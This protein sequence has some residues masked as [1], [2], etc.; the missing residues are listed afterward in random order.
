VNG[1]AAYNILGQVGGAGTSAYNFGITRS[2]NVIRW[3]SPV[4]G[5]FDGSIAYTKNPSNDEVHCN[6]VSAPYS[7]APCSQNYA[8]GGTWYGRVRYNDG[9]LTASLSAFNIQPN[10][11]PSAAQS[12]TG[13]RLGA[14]YTFPIGENGLKVGAVWDNQ[15]IDNFV[16]TASGLTSGKR[17]AYEVPF[18]YIFGKSQAY[19]IYAKA[20]ATSNVP[21][22]GATQIN[23]GYDYALTKNAFVGVIFTR[24]INQSNGTYRPFLTNTSFG[25]TAPNTGEGSSQVS[26]DLNYWF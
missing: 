6:G 2:D 11:V 16:A 7:T 22:S 23:V 21:D 25:P 4:V 12:W 20:N 5:G 19:V 8:H 10:G 13:Y 26:F 3:D 15:E 1:F 9:P 24:L 14:A 18:T 17:N